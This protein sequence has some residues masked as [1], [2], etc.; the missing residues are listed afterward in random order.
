MI[1]RIYTERKPAFAQ[2]ANK[3]LAELRESLGLKLLSELRILRRYDVEGISA[4]L[5][6]A[7]RDTVFR[8]PP[9]EDCFT[10]L[11]KDAAAVINI[12]YLPGQFDQLADSC[13]Q[14]IQYISGG[15]Q[16]AVATA[17]VYLLYGNITDHNLTTVKNY[18]INPVECRE[19]ASD[20][21]DTL[22]APLPPP[23][24]VPLAEGFLDADETELNALGLKHALAMDKNDLLLCQRHFRKE[25]RCPTLTELRVID[26]YWS[27]HCRHTTFNTELTSLEITDEQV[28]SAYRRYLALRQKL[29]EEKPITLMDIA[30]IGARCLSQDGSLPH[31]DKSEEVNA[32]TVKI[33][34][35]VNGQ[36]E[37]WLLLF[38]NETHN[39]PTEIEPFGGAATCLGGAIRDPL[40]GRGYP[41]QAMRLT[42]A[43]DPTAPLAATLF[44]KLPQR[45]LTASAAAGH[46]SYGNQIGVPAGLVQEIYHPGYVAKRME[47]GALLAAAPAARVKR[48]KPKPGDV[49][50]LVGGP[51]G[52]DGCGGAIGSSKAHDASALATLGAEVQK[53]NAPEERKLLRLF[54]NPQASLLIKRCN[55]FGAGGVAVAI[56]ELAAGLDINLDVIPTK[57]S[58][59]NGTELAISESQERMAVVVAAQDATT[60]TALA[61]AENLQAT[62]MARITDSNRMIMRWRGQIIV[63]I[64][65]AFLDSNGA[66]KYQQVKTRADIDSTPPAANGDFADRLRALLQ[67]ENVCSQRG[68]IERFD[69]TAGAGT[70]LAPLGG[71]RQ[72]TPIQAMAAQLPLDAGETTACTLMSYGFNPYIS[73]AS[74]YKGAYLAVVE[75]VAKLIAT[76]GDIGRCWLS[77]QEFFPKLGRS[78]ERW[79]LPVAA[80]LGALSAQLDLDL[81]AIGGKDSMSG[82]FEDLDVP[83]TLVSFA[84]ALADTAHIISPEFKRAGSRVVLFKPKYNTQGLPEASS[85]RSNF[86]IAARLIRQGKVLSAL[87][88]VYGGAAAGLI[89]MCLG[90]R[91]GLR[92]ANGLDEN[93]LFDYCYGAF[94]LELKTEAEE[95]GQLVGHTT[96]AYELQHAGGVIPLEELEQI[97]EKQLEKIFPTR[98]DLP[99]QEVPVISYTSADRVKPRSSAAKPRVLIPV[100]PGTNSEYDLSLA[101]EKAGAAAKITVAHNLNPAQLAESVS[102]IVKELSQ[103]QILALAGDYFGGGEPEGLGKF[104][105]AF[106]RHPRLREALLQLLYE[107][108]GLILGSGSGFKALLML[109]L[110]PFGQF[111]DITPT[112]PALTPNTIGRHQSKL[113]RVRVA[114][115]L[116]PWLSLSQVG[117]IHTVA[118]SHSEG[119]FICGEELF[120]QLS[121][122]GQIAGQYVDFSGRPTMDITYNPF[123][124]YMAVEALCS[125]DGR[126]FGQMSHPERW[127]PGNLQNVPGNMDYPIFASAVAYFY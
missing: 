53:G 88:P 58:G 26:T 29:G 87:T 10:E 104:S 90:N 57:Y 92:L 65:R 111:C 74:P 49:V 24:S 2:E 60:F 71:A 70:V 20:L 16:P 95:I 52:R 45:Q 33:E 63:D 25:G 46:S 38:K 51:T 84:V 35:E 14:C 100:F 44:G 56:G 68:L 101:F 81:A 102:N 28:A 83:P 32:C 6:A 9:V 86:D 7:C 113:A 103:V 127:N 77:F 124:A 120:A 109:G 36:K 99:A 13:S 8:Q 48:E 121:A 3:L 110:L 119:R 64:D 17:R 94:L 122:S 23:Q 22:A 67:D 89:K 39:H 62:P 43:G 96:E 78:P 41:Y 79:G 55:D 98:D 123:G 50:L 19:A 76:G 116:S 114:S 66:K 11:P 21:P 27:D 125:P 85:L 91:L 106:F 1:N 107:R 72:L 12:E 30:T 59:L 80:L 112:S 115:T 15:E 47:A 73:S 18:L 75:S 34:V 105:A 82:S 5:F 108:D 40:S 37:P 61:A 31:W 69:A 42:G 93:S 97:Y 54:R 126:V 117:D 118:V 4:E